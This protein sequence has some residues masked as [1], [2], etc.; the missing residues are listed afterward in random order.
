MTPVIPYRLHDF[1]PIAGVHAMGRVKVN[2]ADLLRASATIGVTPFGRSANRA[3]TVT[4]LLWRVA[5]ADANLYE[6]GHHWR[7]SDS[8]TFLNPT[9]KGAVSYFLGQ[10]QAKIVAETIF[11]VST[12]AQFESYLQARGIPLRRSRPDFIGFDDSGSVFLTVEAKGRFGTRPSNT[13]IASAKLQS[14]AINPGGSYPNDFVYAHVSYFQDDHWNADLYDPPAARKGQNLDIQHAMFA[15]YWPTVS[16][17][18]ERT[19]S[20]F[21]STGMD[22]RLAQ[23]DDFRTAMFPEVGIAIGVPSATYRSTLEFAAQ[24]RGGVKVHPDTGI[25]KSHEVQELRSRFGDNRISVGNDGMICELIDDGS[26]EIQQ[27]SDARPVIP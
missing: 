13:E 20:G 3:P 18:N 16:A 21:E 8:Y 25:V 22:S 23:F 6:D 11:Q 26:R 24:N 9:E 15:H 5:M 14:Q 10:V 7:R 1:R 27:T 2:R 17:I 12:F 19:Q 4:E